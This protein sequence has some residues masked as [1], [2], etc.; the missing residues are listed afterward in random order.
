M[1]GQSIETLHTMLV[2]NN[3]PIQNFG[4]VVISCLLEND[5]EERTF[6]AED[7]RWILVKADILQGNEL[8]WNMPKALKGDSRFAWDAKGES[9]TVMI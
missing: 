3:S 8:I 4:D 2:E 5:V 9:V 1:D 6:K 7:L